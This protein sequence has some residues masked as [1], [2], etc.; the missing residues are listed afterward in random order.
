MCNYHLS[1][2]VRIKAVQIISFYFYCTKLSTL[3]RKNGTS[4]DET[5]IIWFESEFF[6]IDIMQPESLHATRLCVIINGVLQTENI[7]TYSYHH[8]FCASSFWE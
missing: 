7:G 5:C 1:H 4:T 3:I 8:H 2:V 6:G